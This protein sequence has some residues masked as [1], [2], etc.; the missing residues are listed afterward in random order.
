[1]SN[2]TIVTNV[3]NSY[4]PEPHAALINGI[5][6][7]QDL[8]KSLDFYEQTKRVGL[9]HLVVLSG[10]NISL[11]GAMIQ[12]ICRPLGN[13]GATLLTI[14][15][16]VTFVLFVGADPP[17]TRAAIMG[18]ITL[19][20]SLLGRKTYTLYVLATS[21]IMVAIFKTEWLTSVS[22]QLSA[23]ATL[24]I[25]LFGNATIKETRSRLHTLKNYLWVE[26]K[27]SF[28]AQLFTVPIIF[29]NFKE[30][31]LI[32]PFSNLV[33]SFAIAPIMICGFVTAFL[34]FIHHILGLPSALICYGLLEYV[35]TAIRILA[36]VPGMYLTFHGT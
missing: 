33:V 16:I 3:L 21:V 5:L 22:F 9:L 2:I 35:V 7:G 27:P 14:V 18:G 15:G 1:M 30:L 8:S 36:A 26:L 12:I 10:V 24:G 31:S 23:G 17:V 34:G 4:F 29:W 13:K 32:A 28:A 25:I 20:G 11:L 19:V 6:V